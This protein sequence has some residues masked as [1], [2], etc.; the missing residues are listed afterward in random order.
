[1]GLISFATGIRLYN[2]MPL[3][4]QGLV[5]SLLRPIPRR[6][7][8]H[9]PVTRRLAE[10]NAGP[11]GG[12]GL[13]G[14][15]LTAAQSALTDLQA[16]HLRTLLEH[17]AA[18]VPFWRDWFT[19]EGLTVA[20]LDLPADLSRLPVTTKA[21]LR[22]APEAFHS[23][24]PDGRSPGW[25]RTS[26]STGEPLRFMIDQQT[27]AWEYATE[28]RTMGWHGVGIDARVA[29]FRGNHYRDHAKRGAHWY[30]HALSADLNFNTYAMDAAACE[31]YA[32]RL[33]RF[34][35]H[36]LRGFPSS[37]LH[38]ARTLGTGR[39]PDDGPV[40]AGA[41]A[42]TSS[43]MIDPDTRTTIETH[44]VER[45][46]DW[47][48][49]SEYVVSAGECEHGQMHQNMETG[50]LEVLDAD[51]APVA[52]GEVGRLVGT[53]LTNLSQPFIRYDLE[54]DGG[55][56]VE[57]CA[58]GRPLPVMLP[59]QGRSGDV[60]LTPD[61][62][63]LSTSLMIHWWKHTA[64]P[65]HD[66]DLFAWLQIVQVDATTLRLRA[67]ANEGERPEDLDARLQAAFAPLWQDSVSLELEWLDEMPHGE[68]WRFCKQA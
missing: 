51:D 40:A 42:F 61:G 39:G 65:E 9:G 18:H 47:Y 64:V 5:G 10:L 28:W 45:I 2:A 12:A 13:D 59:I 38:L 54:D 11:G 25:V 44:L 20:D 41:I 36:V 62:R 33:A 21:D 4:M 35:P 58:C 8:G 15:A 1:M 31:R 63:A 53:S 46:V 29:T 68:K 34:K 16:A 60:I 52:R 23:E 66:L 17:A 49:Q 22:A 37:L 26:G 56:S 67:V 48:S 19:A 30:R 3:W 55:W 32:R 27:R 57:P 50:L 6:W 7:R 24:A 43:E 14:E